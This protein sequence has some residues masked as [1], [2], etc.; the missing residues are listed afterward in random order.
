MPAECVTLARVGALRDRQCVWSRVTVRERLQ[1]VRRMRDLLAQEARSFLPLFARPA[2]ETLTG[3]VIPLAEACRFL[4]LEAGRLLAPQKLGRRGRPLW[5]RGVDVEVRR[6]PH[7]VVLVIGPANYPLFLPGVQVLQALVAGNA[8]IV[9]PGVDGHA[10]MELFRRLLVRAGVPESL[11]VLLD[12]SVDAAQQAIAS[13]VD[14]I[15][16]TGSF[17][18]GKA[19]LRTAAEHVIPVT[20]ELSGMDPIVLLLSADIDKAVR[21]I[22]F[23]REFNRGETCIAP[24]RVLA[25]ETIAEVVRARVDLPV[26]TFRSI[27]EAVSLCTSSDF[28]LGATVFGDEAQARHLAALLP[29]GVVVVNDMIVPTADPRISFGGRSCS[30]FGKTRGADGLLEMTVAKAVVVQRSRRL[31]HLEAAPA[32]AEKL[33]LGMLQA[34]HRAGR[35]DRMRGWITVCKV[36]TTMRNRR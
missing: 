8:A 24:R 36:A 12:D 21:A 27:D 15:V 30:G 17:A 28:A 34:M 1:V 9:K 35:W 7:G 20:A 26:E 2:A 3:E 14:K 31:R 33:F 19:V 18:S 4:E 10:A 11:F 25:H 23:G 6:D 22:R 5:L 32:G 29:L 16:V 13:G